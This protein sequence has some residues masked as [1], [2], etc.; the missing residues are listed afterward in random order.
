METLEDIFLKG[1]KEALI[2]L[3][4]SLKNR[5]SYITPETLLPA[6]ELYLRENHLDFCNEFFQGSRYKDVLPTFEKEF[7][8]KRSLFKLT[9]FDDAFNF[10]K[11]A[12][13]NNPKLGPNMRKLYDD[14]FD[15]GSQTILYDLGRM[16]GWRE[17]GYGIKNEFDVV[18]DLSTV[19][20]TN[21]FNTSNTNLETS[22]PQ[23][24]INGVETNPTHCN[25]FKW[26][27]NTDK[28][29]RLRKYLIKEEFIDDI[30]E[31]I[32]IH[33]FEGL[34]V[35]PKIKWKTSKYLLI[36]ILDGL[37]NCFIYELFERDSIKFEPVSEHFTLKNKDLGTKRSWE[38]LRNEYNDNEF[39]TKKTKEID[40]IINTLR[41]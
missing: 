4:D 27:D 18:G 30:D 6:K 31:E 25:I 14:F 9:S 36:R 24:N 3:H 28:I 41:K 21:Q 2:Q 7:H 26:S 38:S 8:S 12:L 33:H 20:K 16:A 1:K 37:K 19:G 23:T 10:S 22:K 17:F 32:F 13:L 5:F 15:V 40:W 29:K 34:M 35:E 11:D 39:S